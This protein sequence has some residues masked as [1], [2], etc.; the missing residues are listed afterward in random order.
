MDAGDWDR[1]WRGKAL[2]VHGEPSD[3]VVDVLADVPPGAALDLG[4]GSGRHAVWLAAHG[5]Q[6]TGVDFSEEAL[7]QARAHA[8]A[9]DV[10]VDW[11]NADLG[12]YEP[13][14]GAF[15]LVLVAFVHLPPAEQRSLLANA[16]RAVAP[17][18]ILV[19]MG[20]DPDN[21]GTGAPGPSD[22][23]L[24]HGPDD[25]ARDVS[26]LTVE[27]AEQVRHRVMTHDGLEV[28]AVDSLVVARAE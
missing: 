11:I 20:H 6:V 22:P 21:V 9:N 28:E 24:L 8:S 5:W 25:I 19:V 14:T 18:G 13:D 16:S 1:R 23:T 15:D 10:A 27:R 12:E 2:H 26:S 3:G 4:C 17:G 7:R